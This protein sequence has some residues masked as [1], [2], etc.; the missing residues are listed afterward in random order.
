MCYDDAIWADSGPVLTS[1]W[2][3]ASQHVGK[4]DSQPKHRFV[5]MHALLSTARQL[6]P[7]LDASTAVCII[8]G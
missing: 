4:A 3:S 5:E 7:R 6:K 2:E 8:L 1:A